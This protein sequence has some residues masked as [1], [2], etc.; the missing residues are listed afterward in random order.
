MLDWQDLRFL[1]AVARHGALSGAARDLGVD[2]ATV[3]RRLASLET[4]LDAHVVERLPRSVR[5]T[6][7]GHRLLVHAQD[8][9]TAS[10]AWRGLRTRP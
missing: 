4:A 8:M 10:N 7:L 3:S 5:L 6:A 1:L 9:Q 2:H